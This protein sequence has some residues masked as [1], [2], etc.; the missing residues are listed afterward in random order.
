MSAA[1]PD[2]LQA[3]RVYVWVTVFGNLAWESLHL[4]LYTI[5]VSGTVGE[6]LFAVVHCT[7]GDIL[8][9]LASVAL[10]LVLAGGY[11]FWPVVTLAVV[12][13]VTYAGF[14]EWLN[15]Y[16]R[17]SW[18]YAEWMPVLPVGTYQIGLSPIL[19]WIA[20]PTIALWMARRHFIDNESFRR[21]I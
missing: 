10:A 1:S 21:N 9:A 19:Q 2:W 16:V 3:L 4:P 18:A 15:V 7:G 17:K 8:I 12:F 11:G 6:Q 20:V 13:G 14:S 5:W